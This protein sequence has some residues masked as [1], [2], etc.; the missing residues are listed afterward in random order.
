MF[1]RSVRILNDYCVSGTYL[2]TVEGKKKML[3][4]TKIFAPVELNNLE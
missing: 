2:P 3:N 1:V 4:E